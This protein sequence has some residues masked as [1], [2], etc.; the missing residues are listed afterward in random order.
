MHHLNVQMLI[1]SNS[2]NS[3]KNQSQ[4]ICIYVPIYLFMPYTW[5][6][7]KNS[8]ESEPPVAERDLGLLIPCV[9]ILVFCYRRRWGWLQMAGLLQLPGLHLHIKLSIH[10]PNGDRLVVHAFV[11]VDDE[12]LTCAVRF[13]PVLPVCVVGVH[14]EAIAGVLVHRHQ[15]NEIAVVP[16][17]H[18]QWFLGLIDDQSGP[19]SETGRNLLLQPDK[20]KRGMDLLGEDI[21]MNVCVIITSK[22]PKRA[23]PA[24]G[25]FSGSR[26]EL[27]PPHRKERLSQDQGFSQ[28]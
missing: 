25:M 24:L 18:V 28:V 21:R 11:R 17:F 26:M 20:H 13:Q 8:L 19:H 15:V 3:G 1:L 4:P 22:F 23:I 12:R 10:F 14:T 7:M 6:Q 27:L 5:N 2:S 9:D 16:N